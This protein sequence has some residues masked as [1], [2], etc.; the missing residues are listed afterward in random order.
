MF[1][2]LGERSDQQ[3]I[4]LRALRKEFVRTMTMN[5]M[6]KAVRRRWWWSLWGVLA[7]SAVGF[8][9]YS[10]G[11]PLT[12][13]GSQIPLDPDVPPH[14]L[15]LVVHGL[16]GCLALMTG[17]FQFADR[18]RARYP[19]AHRI[20]GRVYLGS[21]LV[22]AVAA[23]FAATF[24]LSGFSVQVAFYILSTAWIYTLFRAYQAIRRGEVQLHRIWM[25]RNYALTFAAATLRVYLL[26]GL[27]LREAFPALTFDDVYH[28][29]AWSSFVGNVLVAEYFIVHRTLRPLARRKAPAQLTVDLN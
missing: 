14:W 13:E 29:A 16:P 6:S 12:G 1:A 21:V 10:A 23:F 24:S 2:V 28:A 7:V 17:P 15:A 19:K 22:G 25:I 26:S 3:E 5:T 18:L 20:A 9:V 8:A 4:P 27:A 11:P